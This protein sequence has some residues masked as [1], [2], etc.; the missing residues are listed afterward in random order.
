M[1]TLHA[2]VE[3]S[4]ADCDGRY[5]NDYV[6]RPTTDE[7][8]YSFMVRRMS[9][10]T[11]PNARQ[12]TLTVDNDGY[13]WSENTEEG[14]VNVQVRWCREDCADDTRYRDHTAEAAG[15]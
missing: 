2:H 7:D 10:D 11:S 5:N 15:Y 6:S 3:T 9:M 8:D 4:T 12:A 1:T 13:V 14:F